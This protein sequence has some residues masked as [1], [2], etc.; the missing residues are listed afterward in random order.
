MRGRFRTPGRAVPVEMDS[1]LHPV[2][3]SRADDHHQRR[4]R[5]ARG[6]AGE[7]TR[8]TETKRKKQKKLFLRWT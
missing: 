8:D 5:L 2:R 7:E 3:G 4:R 1:F 6:R